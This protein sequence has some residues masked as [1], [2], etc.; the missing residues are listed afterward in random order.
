[1]HQQRREPAAAPGET[2]PAAPPPAFEEAFGALAGGDWPGPPLE[3]L[4][5]LR[6]DAG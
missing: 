2:R 4:L 6:R 1:M 5:R 3:T